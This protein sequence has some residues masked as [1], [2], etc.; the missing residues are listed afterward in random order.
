MVGPAA[1]RLRHLAPGTAGS[2]L[3]G[4]LEL[5]DLLHEVLQVGEL[6]GEGVDALL[7]LAVARLHDHIVGGH[8]LLLL[9]LLLS[10][11]AAGEIRRQV[12]AA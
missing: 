12:A 6:A 5:D 3:H 2:R 8:Q 4:A 11:T 1:A 7:E 10:V 9:L